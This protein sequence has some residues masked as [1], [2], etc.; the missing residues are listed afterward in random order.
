MQNEMNRRELMLKRLTSMGRGPN[1]LISNVTGSIIVSHDRFDAFEGAGEPLSYAVLGLCTSGGGRTFRRGHG[2]DLD[3]TW[4]PGRLG[5]VLPGPPANG[6]TPD[7]EML[8]ICF[9]VDAIPACRGKK[10]SS[11]DLSRV[12][13]RLF[14]DAHAQSVMIALRHEAEVHGATSTFFEHGLSLVLHRLSTLALEG[15]GSHATFRIANPSLRTL[16]TFIEERLDQELNVRELAAMAEVD[17]KTLTRLFKRETGQTPYSYV[18]LRRMERAKQLLQDKRTVTDTAM[19]VGYANPAKFS[20]AFRRMLGCSPTE[21]IN[22]SQESAE[23][24]TRL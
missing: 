3:D 16:L 7:L 8:T 22:A 23:P 5:L 11:T 18:T 19:A 24:P 10:P 2:V 4:H 15:G 20:A 13:S 14:D 9:D 17:P 12:A 6:R 21:W 1:L